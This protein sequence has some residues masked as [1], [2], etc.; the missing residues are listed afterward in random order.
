MLSLVPQYRQMHADGHFSGVSIYAYVD[1]LEPLIKETGAKSLLDYG[2]GKGRQYVEG[3]I[4]D[5]WGGI[6]PTLYDP[7][8]EGIDAKPEGQFD[9]VFCIDVLE[10][11]PEDELDGV[12]QEVLDYANMWVFFSICCTPA[13]KLLPDGRNVHITLKKE[14]WWLF[15]L[16]CFEKPGGPK[17]HVRFERPGVKK[18]P[19]TAVKRKDLWKTE[20]WLKENKVKLVNPK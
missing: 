20:N 13:K 14:D 12:I 5:L 6:M 1:E 9:G 15:K 2:C 10:H 8:V 7:A 4:Q 17:M 3:N 18:K 11:I 16:S 19:R